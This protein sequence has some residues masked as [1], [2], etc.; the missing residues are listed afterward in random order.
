VEKNLNDDIYNEAELVGACSDQHEI[1]LGHGVRTTDGNHLGLATK[2]SIHDEEYLKQKS[3][4]AIV[5][6]VMNY[7]KK[8]HLILEY[9][10]DSF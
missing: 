3:R 4:D 2:P 9:W 5:N 1:W 8:M 10:L 6:M 7:H